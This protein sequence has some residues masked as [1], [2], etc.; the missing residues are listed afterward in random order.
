[1]QPFVKAVFFRPLPSAMKWR[2]EKPDHTPWEKPQILG[3]R[4]SPAR[5]SECDMV[6]NL[7]S[8]PE[9]TKGVD[10]VDPFGFSELRGCGGPL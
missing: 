6:E 2:A 9:T 4:P 3:Q 5:L 7:H 8:P 1:M 10:G